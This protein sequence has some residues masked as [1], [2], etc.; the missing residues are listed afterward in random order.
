LVLIRSPRC[1]IPE[2][3]I[4]LTLFNCIRLTTVNDEH[5]YLQ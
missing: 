1:L 5:N 4:L 3:G 2:E